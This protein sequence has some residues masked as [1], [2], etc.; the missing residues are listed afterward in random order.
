MPLIT[1]SISPRNFSYGLR[2]FR[3][4]CGTFQLFE[5]YL[6]TSAV[7]NLKFSVIFC[8]RGLLPSCR[9]MFKV[10]EKPESGTVEA[11]VSGEANL[12]LRIAQEHSYSRLAPFRSSPGSGGRDSSFPTFVLFPDRVKKREASK[13]EPAE[14]MQLDQEENRYG[15]KFFSQQE[16]N[17]LYVWHSELSGA[18]EEEEIDVVGVAPSTVL[19]YDERKVNIKSVEHSLVP[20]IMCNLC[21]MHNIV[22]LMNS[23][24]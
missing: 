18:E 4:N 20:P 13:P 14:P 21:F 12:S 11:S 10:E 1:T 9:V 7:E 19:P 22:P 16:M 24:W 5:V 8:T 2:V 17:D 6:F 15:R 23:G 3:T